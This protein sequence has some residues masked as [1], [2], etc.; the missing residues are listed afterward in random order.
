M[1]M[2]RDQIEAAARAIGG[3]GHGWKARA[4]LKLSVSER[5]L[6]DAINRHR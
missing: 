4:A 6:R 5:T 1:T 3:D 2:T